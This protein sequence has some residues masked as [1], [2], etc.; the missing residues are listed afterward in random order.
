MSFCLQ[1][2]FLFQKLRSK[3]NFDLVIT[4]FL[5][6]FSDFGVAEKNNKRHL[7]GDVGG[8]LA[9]EEEGARLS[10]WRDV[11]FG[12]SDAFFIFLNILL[13]PFLMEL[14][15]LG[16][17]AHSNIYFGFF[18]AA[19]WGSKNL[20]LKPAFWEGICGV[21]QRKWGILKMVPQRFSIRCVILY[22]KLGKLQGKPGSKN[23][24]WRWLR[25]LQTKGVRIPGSRVPNFRIPWFPDRSGVQ[26]HANQYSLENII[27]AVGQN[28]SRNYSRRRKI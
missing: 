5:C 15:D 6:F 20:L 24:W 2:S 3:S 19:I 23:D 14:F 21:L 13:P 11:W 10:N 25:S 16:K 17:R 4:F 18:L 26:I 9:G 1:K 28:F 8:W 27:F 12:F 7:P 22:R